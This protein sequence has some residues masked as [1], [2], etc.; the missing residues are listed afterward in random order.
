MLENH[1][2]LTFLLFCA[3]EKLIS[4]PMTAVGVAAN[5]KQG[6]PLLTSSSCLNTKPHKY[7]ITLEAFQK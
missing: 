6:H 4:P 2:D 5:E 3:H 7:T 1:Q